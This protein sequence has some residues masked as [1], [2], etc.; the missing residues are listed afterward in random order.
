V[1]EQ[2]TNETHYS[3]RVPRYILP[4]LATVCWI[5]QLIWSMAVCLQTGTP[6]DWSPGVQLG[7]L[8]IL[9]LY[10]AASWIGEAERKAKKEEHGQEPKS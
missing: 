8:V 3:I 1:S 4:M 5:V 10:A 6:K 9:T 7:W 2:P